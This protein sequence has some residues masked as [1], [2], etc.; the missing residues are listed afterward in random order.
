MIRA[1]NILLVLTA[2]AAVAAVG[3]FSAVRVAAYINNQKTVEREK[4]RDEKRESLKQD[5]LDKMGTITVGDT[6]PDH[7]FEDLDRNPVKLSD[8]VK[9]KTNL[10]FFAPQCDHCDGEMETIKKYAPSPSEQEYFV[11]ISPGNPRLIEEMP[12]LTGLN[13]LILYDHRAEYN[14]LI[15]I[16]TYPFNIVVN[17]NLVVTD[18]ITEPLSGEDIIEIIEENR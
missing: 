6:L 3:Y 17:R 9:R 10:C 16:F 5:I 11:L 4:I 12:G 8:I 1:R 7:V 14:N 18:L 13:S 15:N 2:V